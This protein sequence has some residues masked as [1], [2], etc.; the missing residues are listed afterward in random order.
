MVSKGERGAIVVEATLSLSFFLFAMLTIL[1]ITNI[2][3]AQSKIGTALN[4]SAREISEYSYLYKLTGLNDKQKELAE[5]GEEASQQVGNIKQGFSQLYS[6]ISEI[7]DTGSKINPSDFTSV[8]EAADNMENNAQQAEESLSQIKETLKD[9]SDDP[10]AFILGIGAFMV[11]KAWEDEKTELSGIIC[12]GF[13]KKHL[14]NKKG[15]DCEKYLSWLRLVPTGG[16]YLDSLD[17]D[18]SQVFKDGKDSKIDLVVT[19]KIRVI[20]LLGFEK[21]FTFTQRAQTNGWFGKS[22]GE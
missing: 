5:K 14:T 6:S 10:K 15:G 11:N 9:I 7:S 19:Y 13:M 12:R 18:Q 16:S 4:D 22:S 17:F 2:C 8:W 3:L 1:S 21:D 20:R